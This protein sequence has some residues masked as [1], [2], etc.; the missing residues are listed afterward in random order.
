MTLSVQNS[1]FLVLNM[2][3]SCGSVSGVAGGLTGVSVGVAVAVYFSSRQKLDAS[4]IT[5]IT[6]G[7][8]LFNNSFL[9]LILPKLTDVGA[10]SSQTA[11]IVTN[12]TRRSTISLDRVTAIG[13][14]IT[15]G[16]NGPNL[17]IDLPALQTIGGSLNISGDIKRLVRPLLA[18]WLLT[19]TA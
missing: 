1:K 14:N 8:M 4:N 2:T 16:G 11:L 13:G 10:S 17:T 5:S 9:D 12:N 7:A 3:T 19:Y 15:I 6:G 18:I